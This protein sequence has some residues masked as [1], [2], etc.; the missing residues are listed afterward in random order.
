MRRY[1]FSTTF[2]KKCK[3]ILKTRGLFNV[4]FSMYITILLLQKSLNNKQLIE[5]LRFY[6]AAR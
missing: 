5:Y 3:T 6:R 2:Y 1:T 4:Y